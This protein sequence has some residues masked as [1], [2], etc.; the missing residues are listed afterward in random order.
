MEGGQSLPEQ[1][2]PAL[3]G[4]NNTAFPF[5]PTSVLHELRKPPRSLS[6]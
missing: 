5:F 1:N 4:G 2:R 3:G 6:K